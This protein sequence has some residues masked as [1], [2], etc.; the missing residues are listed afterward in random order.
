MIGSE[1]QIPTV[2]TGYNNQDNL[3]SSP[4]AVTEDNLDVT[5]IKTQVTCHASQNNAMVTGYKNQGNSRCS[6]DGMTPGINEEHSTGSMLDQGQLS[7]CSA[8]SSF[9]PKGPERS[10]PVLHTGNQK[11]H[12][13]HRQMD[14][15]ISE[16]QEVQ[17][18]IDDEFAS[19]DVNLPFG[20]EMISPKPPETLRFYFQNANSIRSE[21]MEKWLDDCVCMRAKEVDIFG[22]VE[23]NVNLRHPG[24]TEKVGQIAKRNWTHAYTTLANAEA[25]CR[26]WAQQGGTSVTTTRR[27]VSRLVER[28]QDSK[29][30]RWTYPVLRGKGTQKVVLISGYQVCQANMAGPLTAASQQWYLLR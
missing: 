7:Y 18:R 13:A 19:E 20:D 17:T 2:V 10:T 21:R 26:V 16:K 9:S 28:R 30:G 27:W 1:N 23:I 11:Q 4:D 29:L 24:L 3:S 5:G 15:I 14:G 6:L 25:D 8:E 22:L 12:C